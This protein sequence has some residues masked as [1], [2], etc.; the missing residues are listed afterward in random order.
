MTMPAKSPE[1]TTTASSMGICDQCARMG[2]LVMQDPQTMFGQRWVFRAYLCRWH[3]GAQNKWAARMGPHFRQLKAIEFKP[4]SD[5]LPNNAVS[6]FEA[7]TS[8]KK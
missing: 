3:L 2:K 4:D 7:N 5:L 6:N 8:E 1:T